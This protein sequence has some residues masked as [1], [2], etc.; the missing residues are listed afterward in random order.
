MPQAR[1]QGRGNSGFYVQGRYEV[2]MLDSFGLEG[3]NNEC[4]GIY[5]D[6]GRRT[7]TCAFRRLP[8]QT[9]DVDFTAAEFDDDGKWSSNPR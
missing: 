5:S 3:K 8:W 9:Y 2:Q 4:G 7:S 6:R 1:G